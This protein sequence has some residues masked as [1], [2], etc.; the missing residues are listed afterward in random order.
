MFFLILC[1]VAKSSKTATK[2]R[3]FLRCNLQSIKS[4]TCIEHKNALTFS[5]LSM[6]CSQTGAISFCYLI[7]EKIQSLQYYWNVHPSSV[8]FL[9]VHTNNLAGH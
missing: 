1:T 9:C 2:A 3:N 7:G 6:F 4:H 8:A 5:N